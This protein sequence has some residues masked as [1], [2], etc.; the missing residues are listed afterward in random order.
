MNERIV[1]I[2]FPKCGSC[3]FAHNL[4]SNMLD[5]YGLPPTP[6]VL[7]AS[8]DALGRQQ[9]HIE[10]MSPKVNHDRSACTLYDRKQDFAT[11]GRS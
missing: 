7:G 6:H 10:A 1:S 9:F 4:K 2:T 11:E 3:K 8:Q 5:C